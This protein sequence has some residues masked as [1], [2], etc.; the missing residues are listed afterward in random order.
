MSVPPRLIRLSTEL[1][2][3]VSPEVRESL[4][5]IF[6]DG[7]SGVMGRRL[8]SL[9]A[10][11]NS[12]L[13]YQD[14]LNLGMEWEDQGELQSAGR[15]YHY[16]QKQFPDSALG[17]K[18]ESRLH[19]MLGTGDSLSRLEF[20]SKSF[21]AAATDWKVIVPMI[22][23]SSFYHLGRR[24]LF[25]RLTQSTSGAWWSEGLGA[26]ALSS[27]GAFLGETSVFSLGSRGL[28]TAVGEEVPWDLASV[29]G[30]WL[31]AGL[32]LG[33]LKGAGGVGRFGASR[34][35]L[36]RE[37]SG[38]LLQDRL[39]LG[40]M[41]HG[42][43]YLGLVGA[44]ELESYLGWSEAGASPWLD[45]MSAYLS[46]TLGA[47]LGYG[48]LGRGFAAW[49]KSLEADPVAARQ[50]NDLWRQAPSQLPLPG[51]PMMLAMTW[52][53]WASRGKKWAQ[54]LMLRLA[55]GPRSLHERQNSM[56]DFDWEEW[57]AKV[58]P[59]LVAG[60]LE[61]FRL[62]RGEAFAMPSLEQVKGFK[63][64]AR[65]KDIPWEVLVWRENKNAPQPEVEAW[66][67]R[68][69]PW[70]RRRASGVYGFDAQMN[71]IAATRWHGGIR[72]LT[73]L[74][75]TPEMLAPQKE[76]LVE[77]AGNLKVRSAIPMLR[78]L[79]GDPQEEPRLR[80]KAAEVLFRLGDVPSAQAALEGF[81]RDP[82]LR[83]DHMFETRR[84]L[85]EM[86]TGQAVS[87]SRK[88]LVPLLDDILTFGLTFKTISEYPHIISSSGKT[89]DLRGDFLTARIVE[90]IFDKFQK[91][92]GL[93][94]TQ[95]RIGDFLTEWGTGF[96]VAREMQDYWKEGPPSK[97][98]EKNLN[99][100]ALWAR[101]GGKRQ[102][103]DYLD[104]MISD[105]EFS[106]S[107]DSHALG[108]AEVFAAL[109]NGAQAL[110]WAERAAR[111]PDWQTSVPAFHLLEQLEPAGERGRVLETKSPNGTLSHGGVGIRD[112]RSLALGM[113]AYGDN[114]RLMNLTGDS[115]AWGERKFGRWRVGSIHI[116]R[117]KLVLKLERVQEGEEKNIPENVEFEVADL[118]HPFKMGQDVWLVPPQ[119]SGGIDLIKN[120]A[121]E[122]ARRNRGAEF[123]E[124]N[125]RGRFWLMPFINEEILALLPGA[126]VH[127]QVV[128]YEPVDPPNRENA[129]VRITTR[130]PD[131]VWGQADITYQFSIPYQ[132]GKTLGMFR[133]NR[134][135]GSW[136]VAPQ[137]HGR[138]VVIPDQLPQDA[139]GMPIS[140]HWTEGN[141]VPADLPLEVNSD[142]WGLS[143]LEPATEVTTPPEPMEDTFN[144]LIT[145]ERLGEGFY[146][147]VY[148]IYPQEKLLNAA[149]QAM[150]PAQLHQVERVA[151][152]SGDRFE[153]RLFFYRPDRRPNNV[154]WFYYRYEDPKEFPYRP[155][156]R[157]FLI[158]GI[159][160]GSGD[161]PAPGPVVER[162][163]LLPDTKGRY[164]Q[165]LG[166]QIR[167][168]QAVYF[169]T[170]PVERME[171]REVS[172]PV[173]Q[174]P[175][176]ILTL[177]TR[178]FDG[179]R[180]SYRLKS[181]PEALN[182]LGI[183]LMPDHQVTMPD[184]WAFMVRPM[185]E[186]LDQYRED[187]EDTLKNYS[188]G[189]D[190]LTGDIQAAVD[191]LQH[192][193]RLMS[194]D[195]RWLTQLLTDYG[196]TERSS[197]YPSRVGRAT[198]GKAVASQK[199][200]WI[201]TTPQQAGV[202]LVAAESS[203]AP[204][205]APTWEVVRVSSGKVVLGRKASNPGERPK[206]FLHVSLSAEDH[207][208]FAP[209]QRYKVIHHVSGAAGEPTLPPNKPGTLILKASDGKDY[210]LTKARIE[211]SRYDFE[212][213]VLMQF[214]DL[215]EGKS[216]PFRSED[217]AYRL[218][219]ARGSMMD[220]VT[221]K[222]TGKYSEY[223]SFDLT[224]AEAEIIG[225][226]DLEKVD[227]IMKE[228]ISFAP[229]QPR[230]SETTDP[231]PVADPL[232]GDTIEDE[233]VKAEPVLD[234][235]DDGT[236]RWRLDPEK[237]LVSFGRKPELVGD[238]GIQGY[239]ALT[240]D[241]G[242]SSQHAQIFYLGEGK[243]TV[244]NTSSNGTRVLGKAGR[245]ILLKRGEETELQ[246]GDS[247][248]I[249]NV[250]IH[251]D[252][253]LEFPKEPPASS[254]ERRVIGGT[255]E[256]SDQS[257]A[258]P[259]FPPVPEELTLFPE[260]TPEQN[261]VYLG[262]VTPTRSSDHYTV[263]RVTNPV[264][265]LNHLEIKRLK[266]G[267]WEVTPL[268]LGGPGREYSHSYGTWIQEVGRW[269][270]KEPGKTFQL[271]PG[272]L[273]A[274]GTLILK[275]SRGI[276]SVPKANLSG[277]L[278]FRVGI[279]GRT[280]ERVDQ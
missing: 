107:L 81:G 74:L 5:Q 116:K 219:F 161:S 206:G 166:V 152:A 63:G 113:L 110:H 118:E 96:R 231:A 55:T 104:H 243:F 150:F 253:P 171:W 101:A 109:E 73:D 38:I 156:D 130:G 80:M 52:F 136:Q 131:P 121:A 91:L 134:P 84:V 1:A 239:L 115:Y 236:W 3:P 142:H 248:R 144:Y 124:E 221:A 46:L 4:S 267:N 51:A 276:Y 207:A 280:L 244:R 165:L 215:R 83:R 14:L 141:R 241:K 145:R 182:S 67:D 112:R 93:K 111:S 45:G 71:F 167:K 100:L 223:V 214:D 229:V 268:E 258:V 9:A 92:R 47:K 147:Q 177:W 257:D 230:F 27:G 20:Q 162:E 16:L 66:L 79:M 105:P 164:H 157:L 220:L 203:M 17:K 277:A 138:L 274:L 30:D 41:N 62:E 146:D 102:V 49:Q 103:R 89:E 106:Q 140:D 87:D 70:H 213:L 256:I 151:T 117:E 212:S 269:T 128:G 254:R 68:M 90:C 225:L 85:L 82:Y 119:A 137:F 178:G 228:E 18:A 189:K 181:T 123:T 76:R 34:Y 279:D 199:V 75:N 143:N 50:W 6:P 29:G 249:G 21:L 159:Q 12:S 266:N 43:G 227:F 232:V 271:Y 22:A 264:V 265:A 186:V 88:A 240:R 185:K 39:L 180:K 19:G 192:W 168:R 270:K 2:N 28:L 191:K 23:A 183:Q 234:M 154:A 72:R 37:G 35:A 36:A 78:K 129:S 195:T 54:R 53:T 15:I 226:Q 8:E 179:K 64:R 125:Q 263:I 99:D 172:G 94:D 153:A 57:V 246:T 163:T 139:L 211:D 245:D 202:T 65:E 120:P 176:I 278:V 275:D 233:A 255:A 170:A 108:I 205:N 175:G 7:L 25:T 247:L 208:H 204:Q 217:K 26:K 61:E 149:G 218:T 197:Q 188:R 194:L 31:R 86:V 224:E 58:Q 209:G 13:F 169:P 135:Q 173:S 33:F 127:H 273:L 24:A 190:Y 193:S 155:G 198:S 122:Y 200:A 148:W 252:F 196:F 11:K 238:M 261:V 201:G 98:L 48:A 69:F 10:E 174:S 272:Q 114:S 184:H 60:R 216:D 158:K 32:T 132:F 59:E 40:L 242:V 237:S 262:R 222:R 251:L 97:K 210:Q 42:S 259:D 133:R 260:A 56:L 235:E 95:S 77:I 187:L 44:H 160:G 250:I 126:K